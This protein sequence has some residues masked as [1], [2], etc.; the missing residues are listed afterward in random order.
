MLNNSDFH[1]VRYDYWKDGLTEVR[2]AIK[3]IDCTLSMKNLDITFSNAHKRESIINVSH[4]VKL[5]KNRWHCLAIKL[6]R[7]CIRTKIQRLYILLRMR[8]LFCSCCSAISPTG[9]RPERKANLANLGDRCRRSRRRYHR[10]RRGV[11]AAP[12]N[13]RKNNVRTGRAGV[14][15]IT[16]VALTPVVSG[17]RERSKLYG[18]SRRMARARHGRDGPI[19]ARSSPAYQS[20]YT[21]IY[22]RR[23]RVALYS[24]ATRICAGN[25][26]VPVYRNIPPVPTITR[27][28]TLD[29]DNVRD[30]GFPRLVFL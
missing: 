24:Y 3:R 23:R 29:Y 5:R 17:S 9:Y 16:N 30:E 19:V 18:A 1:D 12:G 21:Y 6:L 2:A 22:E 20:P 28:D 27:R 14:P 7:L 25:R 11:P 4:S 15:K 26:A 10:H 8:Q 13:R